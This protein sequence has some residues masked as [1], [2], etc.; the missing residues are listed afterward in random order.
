MIRCRPDL[1][2][3]APAFEDEAG[4]GRFSIWTFPR[5]S[6]RSEGAD[7]R[8]KSKGEAR[9]LTPVDDDRYQ[10]GFATLLQPSMRNPSARY[11]E[12]GNGKSPVD[13][14]DAKE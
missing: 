2:F 6:R 12:V 9:H 10:S 11:R 5:E 3:C 14:G 13:L 7:K 4:L 8:E 1:G